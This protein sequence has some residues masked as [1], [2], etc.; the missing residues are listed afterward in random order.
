MKA[1]PGKTSLSSQSLSPGA[2]SSSFL[3]LFLLPFLLLLL[4][5]SSAPPDELFV[6]DIHKMVLIDREMGFREEITG[7]QIIDR[8]RYE[9]QVE[10]QVRVTG[11]AVH[12]DL[13]IGATLPATEAP[14]ESWAVWMYFCRK[15][16][17]EWIVEEK[18]KVE[19]GFY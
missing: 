10:V 9:N 7:V 11:W 8:T 6:D 3:L 5:C 2:P 4:S 15:V 1:E 14:A 17:K 19:E 18:Y 12:Q 16:D 13:T